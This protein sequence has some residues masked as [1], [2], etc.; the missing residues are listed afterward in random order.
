MTFRVDG[1]LIKRIAKGCMGNTLCFTALVSYYSET[2]GYR[3]DFD[4]Q[5]IEN[6]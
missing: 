3:I 5:E 6:S 1:K 4:L 2:E